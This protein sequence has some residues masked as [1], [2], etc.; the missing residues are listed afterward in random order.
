MNTKFQ[1]GQSG[2]PKG[3]PCG[4]SLNEKLRKAV[5]KD[6]DAIVAALIGQAK[7]GDVQAANVLLTRTCPTL[8]PTQEPIKVDMDGDTLT[9]KAGAILDAVGRA[10]LSPGDAKQL[11]DGL[12][13]VAKIAEVDDL[14]KR[15]EALEQTPK[16]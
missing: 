14:T 8:R 13:A 12:A 4:T 5:S 3:R 6:F 16:R 15:I 1:A 10:E 9:D 11:L 7:N 2:N